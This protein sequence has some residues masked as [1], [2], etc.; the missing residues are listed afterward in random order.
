MFTY[1]KNKYAGNEFPVPAMQSL[2]LAYW[3]LFQQEHDVEMTC[4]ININMTSSRRTAVS[5]TSFQRCV[6]NGIHLRRHPLDEYNCMVVN[7][8]N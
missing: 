7:V 4:H 6:P 8:G 1:I 2:L 5:S 3:K